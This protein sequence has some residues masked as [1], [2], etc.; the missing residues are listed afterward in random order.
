MP[1]IF[2]FVFRPALER[3]CRNIASL[4]VDGSEGLAE[5]VWGK[6]C[7]PGETILDVG[8][9]RCAR[10]GVPFSY[11]NCAVVE[12]EGRVI[13]LLQAYP[14]PTSNGSAAEDIEPPFRPFARLSDG[15]SFY[16]SALVV[17]AGYRGSGIG[18]R[19]LDEAH[20]RSLDHGS[21]RLSVVVLQQNEAA[22]RFYRRAGFVEVDRTPLI[23]HPALPG[24]TGD[25]VLLTKHV[26]A[27]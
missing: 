23:P 15:G 17:A 8:A 2:D 25:A 7:R 4:F 20:Q 22:M 19:L 5:L 24:W 14:M 1:M 13:A 21:P 27:L 26:H 16:L 12:T 3:D 18:S 10:T 6:E 9:R 11:E